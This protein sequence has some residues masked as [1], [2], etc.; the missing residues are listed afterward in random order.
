MPRSLLMST[1]VLTCQRRADLEGDD[2][3]STPEWKSLISEQYGHLYARVVQ[4][5]MRYFE[6]QRTYTATGAASYP[7]PDDHDL[8]IGVE[9]VIDSAGNTA[10]LDE[11]MIQERNAFSGSTGEACAFSITG[12]NLVLSPRPSTGTYILTYIPQSP[13][14]S[15]LSDTETIDVVTADGEAF[16]IYGVAVKAAMK[17]KEDARG[18]AS[19]RDAAEQR[20]IDDVNQ[21]AFTQPRRR[22]VMRS[23]LLDDVGD[24]GLANDPGS[25]RYR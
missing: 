20:F 3:L 24:W 21:R 9:R 14:L 8:Y 22:V 18:Y 5:G 15:S 17:R 10:Q 11:L 19:E 25:W 7:L 16:L 2:S 6:A 23:P 13:D 1:V 4:S 12:L